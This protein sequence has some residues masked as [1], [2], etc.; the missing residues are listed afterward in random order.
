MAKSIHASKE[1]LDTVSPEVLA[2]IK[3]RLIEFKLVPADIEIVPDPSIP[4]PQPGTATS[5]F[6]G[7][8][9]DAIGNAVGVSK[10]DLVGQLA[11]T[12]CMGTAGG[13]ALICSVA[14]ELAKKACEG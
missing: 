14:G 8:V 7:N 11:Y 2:R 6:P 12:A 10:C 5:G 1:A 9:L 13:N 4:P 3:D